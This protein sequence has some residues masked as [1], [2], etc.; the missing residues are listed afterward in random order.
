[1]YTRRTL[2]YYAQLAWDAAG[3]KPAV[4][5]NRVEILNGPS[6]SKLEYNGM[7]SQQTTQVDVG[8]LPHNF[9]LAIIGPTV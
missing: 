7:T 1:M 6:E 4:W 3:R 2:H 5:S 9:L 8:R